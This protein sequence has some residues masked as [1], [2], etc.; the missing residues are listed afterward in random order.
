MRY[1]TAALALFLVAACQAPAI[2]PAGAA[3]PFVPGVSQFEGTSYQN[4]VIDVDFPDPMVLKASDGW[5]YAYATQRPTEKG[6]INVPVQR[7]RDLIHWEPVGDAMPTKP[8]WT[9]DTQNIWAPH[10]LED[11]GKYYLYFSGERNGR[12]GHGVGVAVADSPAGPFVGEARPLAAG[13][14]FEHI[15]PMPFDDPKTGKKYLY[16]GSGFRP[17]KVRELAADRLRFAPGSEVRDVLP[18]ADR[19]YER[20]IEGAWVVARDG[21][22]YLFYSGDDCCSDPPKYVTLVAR[23]KS[24]L[25]PFQR[26]ADATG[27]PDSVI[28]GDG[29]RFKGAGHN[30]I[31]TDARGQDWIVYH[32]RDEREPFL[33]GS[34]AV[35]R[36]LLL[37]RLDWRDGWPAVAGGR[38]SEA[39][40]PGPVVR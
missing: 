26:L 24:P 29:P 1:T 23:A 35:R 22:Y 14:G 21:W 31:V 12:K 27:E 3:Q 18:P 4:P 37:D 34:K 32:A 17:I 39:R 36:P 30:A 15:D 10:V 40:R 13:E 16:W 9:R 25:G 19:P 2:R 6:W 20:L 33:P 7:S 38:P 11:G 5:C 8:A 28:L